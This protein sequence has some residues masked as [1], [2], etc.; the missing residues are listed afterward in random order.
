MKYE[1]NT[2]KTL[3]SSSKYWLHHSLISLNKKLD[4][5]LHFYKADTLKIIDDLSNLYKVDNIFC[6]EPFL[7]QDI[8][9]FEKLS[10]L[11]QEKNIT[12]HTKNCTLLWRP[13]HI[14]KSDDTPYKVFTPFYRKGCLN[15][16]PPKKP[17]N[18]HI[19]LHTFKDKNSESLNSLNLLPKFKWYKKL[20]THWDIG[21]KGAKK[22]FKNIISPNETFP[23]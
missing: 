21:E 14:L 18:S 11:C 15:A 12:L 4:N 7:G 23:H 6:E 1:I 13:Y 8:Y 20:E 5:N 2:N 17:I 9:L 19:N 3:G 22:S 10:V 16:T